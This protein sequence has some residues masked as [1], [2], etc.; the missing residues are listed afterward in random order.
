MARR[1]DTWEKPRVPSLQANQL[2]NLREVTS[3]SKTL[4]TLNTEKLT[5]ALL[6]KISCIGLP[7]LPAKADPSRCRFEGTSIKTCTISKKP[8]A[9]G[10]TRE[11]LREPNGTLRIISR[12]VR[13]NNVQINLYAPGQTKGSFHQG[14]YSQSGA[15][16]TIFVD[17]G[18]FSYSL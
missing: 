12:E 6:A 5:F 4:M 1:L 13:G 16:I 9:G 15:T 2:R 8:N 14:T 3:K 7:G 18:K 11:L 10:W 17:G